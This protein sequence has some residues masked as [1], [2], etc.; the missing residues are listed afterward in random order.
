[1]R[2]SG[3]TTLMLTLGMHLSRA[4]RIKGFY[5]SD[6]SS[7]IRFFGPDIKKRYGGI[8]VLGV[9]G[10]IIPEA[11]IEESDISIKSD[12]LF[13][14]YITNM[15]QFQNPPVVDN[16][17][18]DEAIRWISSIKRVVDSIPKDVSKLI[19]QLNNG[20]AVGDIPKKFIS[21]ESGKL[22]RIHGDTSVH[23][24]SH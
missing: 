4:G 12:L 16:Y 8:M 1:M 5:T 9:V 11:R 23:Q 7:P 2:K 6:L 3:L 22:E 19:F 17:E 24:V 14:V 20:D 15:N 18:S 10:V 21:V 13:S